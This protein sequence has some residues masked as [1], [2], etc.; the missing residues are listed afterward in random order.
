MATYKKV[1]FEDPG[2]VPVIPVVTPYNFSFSSIDWTVGVTTATLSIPQ[3]VH[4]KSVYPTVEVYEIV[5]FNLERVNTDVKLDNTGLVT[6]TVSFVPDLRF[7]G[8]LIIS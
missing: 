2:V 5:A 3:S 7:S 1:G 6:I 8:R 4:L